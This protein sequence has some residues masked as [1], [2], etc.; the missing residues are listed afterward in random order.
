MQTLIKKCLVLFIA[1]CLASCAG[2]GNRQGTTCDLKFIRSFTK[3]KIGT[4]VGTAIGAGAGAAI[5]GNKHR[6]EGVLIGAAVG[7]LLGAG[8]GYLL[9]AQDECDLQAKTI[10]AL[11][12]VPRNQTLYWQS[13]RSNASAEITVISESEELRQV[14]VTLKSANGPLVAST[15]LDIRSGPDDTYDV[16][17]NLKSGSEVS[18]LG[19]TESGWYKVEKDGIKGYAKQYDLRQE[20]S[21][22]IDRKHH[23]QRQKK[24]DRK[25]NTHIANKETGQT[26]TASMEDR[27]IQPNQAT[28]KIMVNTK[29]KCKTVIIRSKK[30]GQIEE[31]TGKSCPNQDGSWGA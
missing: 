17:K 25:K 7:A 24:T 21:I 26:G 2:M 6:L 30:N 11:N 12:T 23:K 13:K 29:V 28:E 4:G 8:V 14:P 18:A 19:V 9:D 31:S 10:E 27:I 3:T 20:S 22:D 5:G 16:I 1:L 15:R